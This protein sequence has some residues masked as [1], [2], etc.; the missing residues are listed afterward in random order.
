MEGFLMLRPRGVFSLR[1]L[2]SPLTY[3]AHSS[4]A[5][6]RICCPPPPC[7]VNILLILANLLLSSTCACKVRLAMIKKVILKSH[8]ETQ[9][10]TLKKLIWVDVLKINIRSFFLVHNR[11]LFFHAFY[12]SFE[13][14]HTSLHTSYQARPSRRWLISRSI[15]TSVSWLKSLRGG[16]WMRDSGLCSPQWWF[17]VT[18]HP[19]W[20]SCSY[21]GIWTQEY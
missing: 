3:L 19:P 13:N 12:F 15:F 4:Q 16:R 7:L 17:H 11:S 18:C 9:A 10:K 8:K 2:V 5:P 21:W 6:S 20:W 14:I 1:S